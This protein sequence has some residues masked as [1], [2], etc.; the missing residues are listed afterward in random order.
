MA[1]LV[2]WAPWQVLDYLKRRLMVAY[3]TRKEDVNR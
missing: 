2:F 3:R 1:A